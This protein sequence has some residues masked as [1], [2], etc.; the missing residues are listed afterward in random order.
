MTERVILDT[1]PLVALLDA[2]DT[3]HAW[4]VRQFREITGPLLTCE[5]VL[6]EALYLV[7]SLRPAQE[8]ILEWVERGVLLC[9]FRLSEEVA[10]VSA[11]W[12]KY[13]DVPISLADACLVCMSEQHD[14]H[15]LCTLDS[16]FT[17]YRK[18]GREPIPLIIP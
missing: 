3:A 6:A 8:K 12:K 4:T 9:P 2:G 13:S 15:R 18:H 1:G 16:D 11:L 7:R 10:R 17:V 5:P 14:D